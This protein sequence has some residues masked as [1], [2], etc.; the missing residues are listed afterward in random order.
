MWLFWF[1]DLIYCL[2]F[3]QIILE[4]DFSYNMEQLSKH[5]QV[6]HIL[7]SSQLQVVK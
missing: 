4:L 6:K 2:Q 5:I 1:I 7:A 3:L